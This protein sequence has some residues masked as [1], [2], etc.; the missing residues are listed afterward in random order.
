MNPLNSPLEIGVRALVLLAESHPEPLDLA[1][2]A[3]LDH[4]VL[5]SGEL[6]GGPPSLHPGLPARMGE[7]GMKRVVLE[8]ALLVLIRAG[9]AG[10]EPDSSG[11]VY[12]ATDRGPAFV[13]V[14]EA[15]Y[16]EHLR[17]RAAW[18]IHQWAPGIDVRT[19]TH[20]LVSAPAQT[21]L[22][23]EGML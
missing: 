14:L 22:P 4:A 7:L 10:V 15:P 21:V 17:E 11:L 20:A 8:Q 2:L 1:Q 9:L 13:D 6:E 5:H 3:L 19:A 23:T 18:A 12:R 16:V